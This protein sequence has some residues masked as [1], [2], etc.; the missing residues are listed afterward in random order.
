MLLLLL[1]LLCDRTERALKREWEQIGVPARR[2]WR[3]F[4]S[5]RIFSSSSRERAS[6]SSSRLSFNNS[7][8]RKKSET[9]S[10]MAACGTATIRG[11]L[12]A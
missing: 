6:S 2:A 8:E 12:G 4:F 7:T 1:L 11:F 5:C 3:S 9:S 10:D